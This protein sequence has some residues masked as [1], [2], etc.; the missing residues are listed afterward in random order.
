MLNKYHLLKYNSLVRAG[1]PKTEGDAC[2]GPLE[3]EPLEKRPG[4]GAAPK[5]KWEP[6]PLQ[7]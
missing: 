2:F 5:I 3:P 6:E 7:K 4:A 1:E